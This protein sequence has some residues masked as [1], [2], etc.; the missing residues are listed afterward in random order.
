MKK[1]FLVGVFCLKKVN[2]IYK[3]TIYGSV[4]ILKQVPFFLP[5]IANELVCEGFGSHID[6]L[7]IRVG[8]VNGVADGLDKMSFSQAHSA[9]DKTRVI[10]GSRVFCY[11]ISGIGGKRVILSYYVAVETIVLIQSAF[12]SS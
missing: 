1:F 10:G 2:I 3:H 12:L 7:E 11:G 6:D 4:F 5:Y 9:V 8:I